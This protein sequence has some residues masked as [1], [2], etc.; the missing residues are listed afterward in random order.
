M[1]ECYKTSDNKYSDCPPRMADGRHFTDYRPTNQMELLLA[2]D[3]KTHNSFQLRQF[4]QHNGNK[5]MNKNREFAVKYNGCSNCANAPQGVEGFNNGTMLPEKHMQYTNANGASVVVNDPNGLGLG[6]AM[7][8]EN[9]PQ[10]QLPTQG[11]PETVNDCMGSTAMYAKYGDNSTMMLRSCT[12]LGGRLEEH[13][14]Q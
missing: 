3:N 7:Y 12:P 2:A 13:K 8:D 14:M 6:R 11:V 9:L 4:L 1:S 5:L 10:G